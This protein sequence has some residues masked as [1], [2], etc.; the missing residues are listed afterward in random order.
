MGCFLSGAITNTAITKTAMDICV[1]VCKFPC[2]LLLGHMVSVCLILEETAKLFSR[3]AG[4][5]N[6]S[7]N[8]V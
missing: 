7:T 1:R 4:P 2:V 5:L 8:S 3:V 6:I